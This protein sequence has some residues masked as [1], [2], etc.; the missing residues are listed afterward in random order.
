V[1]PF[2]CVPLAAAFH[3]SVHFEVQLARAGR[4]VVEAESDV[5]LHIWLGRCQLIEALLQVAHRQIGLVAIHA[6][7]AL[8]CGEFLSHGHWQRFQIRLAA[9]GRCLGGGCRCCGSRGAEQAGRQDGAS[10]PSI[11]RLPG[12]VI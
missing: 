3:D 8:A 12:K 6:V 2:S 7:A 9:A 11:E 1:A 10:F 5:D 4:T